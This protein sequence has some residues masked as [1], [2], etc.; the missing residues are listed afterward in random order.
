MR[1][2]RGARIDRL[3]TLA[4]KDATLVLLPSLL[5]RE[6][7][8]ALVLFSKDRSVSSLSIIVHCRVR[9]I[10]DAILS[11]DTGALVGRPIT[12]IVCV[13]T[14]TYITGWQSLGGYASVTQCRLWLPFEIRQRYDTKSE[15]VGLLSSMIGNVLS[16]SERSRI[17][18]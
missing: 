15:K 1:A 4:Y 7:L 11:D 5:S 13:S 12:S 2:L 16:L 17:R 3:W 6:S 18:S 9:F 8:M 14:L 10:T